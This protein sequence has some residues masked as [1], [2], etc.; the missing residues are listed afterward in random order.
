MPFQSAPWLQTR[1][2]QLRDAASAME[3]TPSKYVILVKSWLCPQVSRPVGQIAASAIAVHQ[4]L[5][6]GTQK[7]GEAGVLIVVASEIARR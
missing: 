7:N 6:M 5:R 3:D 4:T 2:L 1:A